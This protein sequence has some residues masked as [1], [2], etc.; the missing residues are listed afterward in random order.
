[1]SYYETLTTL[2]V[3]LIP[4]TIIGWRLAD[5]LPWRA[6][7]QSRIF[8]APMIGMAVLLHL[9]V[10]L[11]WVGHG[12]RRPVCLGIVGL[13]LLIS[14][15][16]LRNIRALLA[17]L[18]FVMLFCAAATSGVLYPVWRYAAM[19]PYNDSFTYLVHGQWLQTHAFSEPALQSGNY[20]A[21]TQVIYNQLIGTRMGASFML[22]FVQSLMGS[23]WSLRVY[24]AVIA[25]PVAL[26]ALAVAGAAFAICRRF[27]LALLSGL[28]LG[29]TLNGLNYGA[30]NGFLAQTWG[31]SFAAGSLVLLASIM[32]STVRS[33]SACAALAAWI[34]LALLVSAA[35]HAY[36]EITPFLGATLALTFL[37]AAIQ[38]RARLPRIF[39]LAIWLGILCAIFVNLEWIRTIR[40]VRSQAGAV[41]GMPVDW[42]WWQFPAAA[43][44]LITGAHDQENYLLGRGF[45]GQGCVIGAAVAAIGLVWSFR[46]RKIWNVLPHVF[47]L[48]LGAI[49]FIYFRWMARSP[50]PVGTGQSWS[51]FKLS[52]WISPSLFCLLAIGAAGIAARSR[53]RATI[54]CFALGLISIVGAIRQAQ[55]AGPRTEN[56]RNDTGLAY[57]PFSAVFQIREFTG[58]VP[59][60][61]PI[62]LDFDASRVGIRQVVTYAL[63]DHAVAGDFS[64]DAWVMHFLPPDQLTMPVENCR[65]IVSADPNPPPS[66]R[67]AGNLWFGP[68][69]KTKFVLL[70]ASG[71]YQRESNPTGWWYWT[72]KQLAFTYRV[73]GEQPRWIEISFQYLPVS[74]QRP[75]HLTVGGKTIDISLK[76]GWNSFTSDPI[77]VQNL[78]D[79]CTVQFDCDLPPV[80]L[81]KNDPRLASYLI[82]NLSVIRVEAK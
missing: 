40:A 8:L 75:V 20:P 58:Y 54:V 31:I 59:K 37:A 27:S 33:R 41:V 73:A 60:D 16:G 68:P 3:V 13:L 42:P 17:D 30:A 29:L 69:P 65:W 77:D 12:Y 62:G 63:M 70:S 56:I 36:S 23:D 6:R 82:K 28:T 15:W 9:A 1:M 50:W 2:F 4:A 25:L 44:G 43:M 7:A 22:G 26:C 10:L 79:T 78:G 48:S 51:Q 47:F 80:K 11:G 19:N 55:L 38:F 66:A 57:D 45:L 14:L 21:L 81:S 71:G 61:M 72:G 67:Q 18:I 53:M 52:N 34:P 49:A 5:L 76:G 46:H 24:P 64:S 74:D 32:Q 35:I 39:A